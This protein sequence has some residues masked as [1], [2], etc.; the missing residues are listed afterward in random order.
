MQETVAFSTADASACDCAEL[1]G[2][3]EEIFDNWYPH[4]Q[5]GGLIDLPPPAELFREAQRLAWRA[6]IAKAQ[7]EAFEEAACGNSVEQLPP[8]I[9]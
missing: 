6:F 1:R 2:Q 4:W 8:R 5:P 9:R 3:C 7:R